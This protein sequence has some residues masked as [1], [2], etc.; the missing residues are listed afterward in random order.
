MSEDGSYD[1]ARNP[2]VRLDDVDGS[3]G[4]IVEKYLAESGK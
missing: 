1:P 2:G 4:Y 3:I